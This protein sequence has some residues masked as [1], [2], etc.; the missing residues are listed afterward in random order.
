[1]KKAIV[2]IDKKS[3]YASIETAE[4]RVISNETGNI[5]RLPK[6]HTDIFTQEELE[7]WRKCLNTKCGEELELTY[8]EMELII[9]MNNLQY[10]SNWIERIK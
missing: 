9:V 3:F 1:M 10:R 4:I 5:K 2:T 7:V 6:R 8:V